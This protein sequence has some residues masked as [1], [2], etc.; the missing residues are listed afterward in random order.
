MMTYDWWYPKGD[1]T[2]ALVTDVCKQSDDNVACSVEFKDKAEIWNNTAA[3]GGGFYVGGGLLTVSGGFIRGNKAE[4]TP[5]DVTENGIT[6][7]VTTAYN[8]NNNVGVGGGIY[9][10][11]SGCLTFGTY[12]STNYSFGIY[13][14]TADFAADDVFCSPSTGSQLALPAVSNMVLTDYRN[15]KLGIAEYWYEDYVNADTQYKERQTSSQDSSD[16]G[17]D[18]SNGDTSIIRYRAAEANASGV[19]STLSTSNSTR[20]IVFV[21]AKNSLT[22]I[23]EYACLTLGYNP[24]RV[25][26]RITKQVQDAEGNAMTDVGLFNFTVTITGAVDPADKNYRDGEYHIFQT[27]AEDY[28]YKVTQETK[29]QY[30]ENGNLTQAGYSVVTFSLKAGDSI[31]LEGI[32]I[33]AEVKIEEEPSG[34]VTEYL[35]DGEVVSQG[36]VY[37]IAALNENESLT[38][39]N[40]ASYELPSTGGGGAEVYTISGIVLVAIAVVLWR[41]R[42]RTA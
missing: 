30:D 39:L 5:S 36:R 10:Y 33:G 17:T 14:N 12:D 9:V 40:A 35:A 28:A 41:R 8:A 3:N 18:V 26:L 37:T 1:I 34:Y 24:T 27:P 21:V 6:S 13:S 2:Q 31:L 19:T 11:Y 32:P 25:N 38:C 23:N 4:G 15:H 22:D 42:R 20:K 7:K 16:T 29:D